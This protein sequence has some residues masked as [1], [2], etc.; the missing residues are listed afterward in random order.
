MSVS[1]TRPVD[2]RLQSAWSCERPAGALAVVRA[3][4]IAIAETS[5]SRIFMLL[6]GYAETVIA[7]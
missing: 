2:V 4:A 3:T 6:E 5:V 1:G 7:L